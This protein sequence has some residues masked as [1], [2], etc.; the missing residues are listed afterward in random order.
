MA[1][2]ERGAR[3]ALQQGHISMSF[4]PIPPVLVLTHAHMHSY[5][6]TCLIPTDFSQRTAALSKQTAP[7]GQQSKH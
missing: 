4:V 3:P 6:Y 7:T 1:G 5:T 2:R